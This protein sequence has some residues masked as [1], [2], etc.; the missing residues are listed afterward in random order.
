MANIILDSVFKVR[1]KIFTNTHLFMNV[2]EIHEF[3]N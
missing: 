3:L 1:Q 2:M